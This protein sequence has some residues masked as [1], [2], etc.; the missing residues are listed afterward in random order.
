MLK[1]Q[2][3]N[4]AING[5]T[6]ISGCSAEIQSGKIAVIGPTGAGKTTLLRL[7]AGFD[8]PD[9]GE[10]RWHETVFVNKQTWLPPWCRNVG[11]VFQDLALWPHMTVKQHLDFVLGGKKGLKSSDKKEQIQSIITKTRLVGMEKRF[12]SQLSGGQQQRLAI[13]RAVVGK[14]EILLLDEAFNQQDPESRQECWSI[15][16]EFQ[17]ELGF[18]LLA[19]TH[20]L[21]DFV[22]EMDAV[23]LVESGCLKELSKDEIHSQTDSVLN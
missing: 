12:P 6:I 21:A 22:K 5:Q 13:A 15:V 20:T 11:M 19:V 2:S 14:P 9:K 18:L 16:Q 3:I 1:L 8:K 7:I 10:I 17:K 4:K 23:Y